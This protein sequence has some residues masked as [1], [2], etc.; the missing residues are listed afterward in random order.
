[1]GLFRIKIIGGNK[2]SDPIST[3]F[4][5]LQRYGKFRDEILFTL[6]ILRFGDIGSDGGT[7]SKQLIGQSEHFMPFDQMLMFMKFHNPDGKRERTVKNDIAPF[8]F[9]CQLSII[10]YPFA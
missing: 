10:H 1:M 5:L 7:R 6:C 8:I 3:L 4:R 2:K 9:H